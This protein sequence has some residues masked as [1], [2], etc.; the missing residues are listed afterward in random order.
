MRCNGSVDTAEILP[1]KD[2]I[3]S[4]SNSESARFNPLANPYF[5]G[6]NFSNSFGNFLLA[7][8]ENPEL[9]CAAWHA[10]APCSSKFTEELFYKN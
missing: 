6:H 4:V 8:Q 9:Q 3:L 1:S 10:D 5:P 2:G 7:Q